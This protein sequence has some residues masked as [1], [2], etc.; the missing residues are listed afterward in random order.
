MDTVGE[1][2]VERVVA[3]VD[4]YASAGEAGVRGSQQWIQG[5]G[6]VIL[7]ELKAEPMIDIDIV[8][9]GIEVGKD[10]VYRFLGENPST[11]V[12]AIVQDHLTERCS[13]PNGGE[14]ASMARYSI[15]RPRILVMNAPSHRLGSLGLVIAQNFDLKLLWRCLP[16]K[17][18]SRAFHIASI[19][20]GVVHT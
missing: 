18:V 5:P 12:G 9:V 13:I 10:V 3:T 15:Q 17:R 6:S 4:N 20:K 11:T 1:V 8:K 14:N 2:Q 16:V 7:I 19:E